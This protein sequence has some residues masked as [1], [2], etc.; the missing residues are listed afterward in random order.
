MKVTKPLKNGGRKLAFAFACALAG[1]ASCVAVADDLTVAA[2][3]SLTITDNRTYGTITVNG[4]L[5]IS[6]SG[7]SVT[8]TTM[9]VAEGAKMT[10]VLTVKDG[11]SL[12]VTGERDNNY[13]PFTVSHASGTGNSTGTVNVVNGATLTTHDFL[14]GNMASCGSNYSIAALNVSN[15]TMTVQAYFW[16]A[17][18][19]TYQN[20]KGD[21]CPV[22]ITLWEGALLDT[23]SF[24]RN[25]NGNAFC[26]FR[27]G[28]MK[29]TSFSSMDGGTLV[30]SGDGGHPIDLES[31]ATGNG[32]AL[33][34]LNRG[35]TGV[36]GHALFTGTGG[37]TIRASVWLDA[38]G[39]SG[40]NLHESLVSDFSGPLTLLLPGLRQQA[41]RQIASGNCSLVVSDDVERWFDLHGFDGAFSAIHEGAGGVRNSS[42]SAV[43]TLTVGVN[44]SS[45]ELNRLSGPMSL[46]KEGGGTWAVKTINLADV[47]VLD[48]TLNLSVGCRYWK[49]A[50][51]EVYGPNHTRVQLSG[52]RFLDA[53]GDEIDLSKRVSTGGSG[54]SISINALFDNNPISVTYAERPDGADNAAYSAW[55]CFSN[56]QYV[57]A[58][59]WSTAH[60][61][62]PDTKWEGRTDEGYQND[63]VPPAYDKS[64]CRDPS[65]W[66]LEA[67]TDGNCW[68]VI[69]SQSGFKA[70]NR[71]YTYN[72]TNFAC[73]GYVLVTGAVHVVNGATL[74]VAQP[75]TLAP[76]YWQNDGTVNLAAGCR[77]V[78]GGTA[79][80]RF[81]DL[82]A[83][84][85]VEKSGVNEVAV[86]G[87]IFSNSVHVSGGTLTLSGNAGISSKYW[88]W[89]IKKLK[90]WWEDAAK[91]R[92]EAWTP[93][94][95]QARGL[96]LY[97]RNGA[98][99]N[100][101]SNGATVVSADHSSFRSLLSNNLSAC[102]V[103]V[104]HSD[105]GEGTQTIPVPDPEN[106]ATWSGFVFKLSDSVQPVYSYAFATAGD[107]TDR[108]AV[109]WDFS[110]SDDGATWT[111][112]EDRADEIV[113]TNRSSWIAYNGGFKFPFAANSDA[114][115]LTSGTEVQVDGGAT[116]AF[117]GT[118]TVIDSLKVDVG[119]GCGTL[120]HFNPA[121]NGELRLENVPAGVKLDTLS[122][123]TVGVAVNEAN[124]S[125]WKVLVGEAAT[126]Y[127]LALHDG[128]LV[129]LPA[130]MMIIFR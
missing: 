68:T 128:R 76:T 98:R 95:F 56:A 97:D 129:L 85:P 67:S 2:G 1:L 13:Y 28:R 91:G 109:S 55:I 37:L 30:F 43:A 111:V 69:D 101:V 66:T 45:G 33:I 6:G 49:F 64:Y 47:A 7:A 21:W 80:N 89:R 9:R 62:G 115:V 121:A 70:I 116:L 65:A 100:A 120:T 14:L 122:L 5:T 10:S 123:L 53:A 59:T 58:Y 15:A 83:A 93:N 48:G 22:T 71:R 126:P 61:Y 105:W 99:V 42:S 127:K 4:D 26:S 23:A 103:P 74:N 86:Q 27:G 88:R 112:I 32:K 52:V 36:D 3:E 75:V 16:M 72:P 17:R 25:A 19:G 104:A 90:G 44:G 31:K 51:T 63:L 73:T 46:R 118:S 87:G 40:G 41:H 18:N 92:N 107:H 54:E 81:Y 130:G 60:D 78:V 102:F 50:S 12:T 114:S 125:S 29:A 8:A 57:S 82:P 35:N 110:V 113:A 20:Y 84:F 39:S 94:S 119:A 79:D 108:D 117:A 96:A 77:F 38:S 24:V 11:A 106:E 34:S 124:L